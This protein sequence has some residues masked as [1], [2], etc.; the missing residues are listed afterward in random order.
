[1]ISLSQVLSINAAETTKA[2]LDMTAKVVEAAPYSIQDGLYQ[3]WPYP[4][5]VAGDGA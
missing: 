3:R 2:S 4:Q 1:M 5:K